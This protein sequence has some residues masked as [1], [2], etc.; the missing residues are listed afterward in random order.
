VDARDVNFSE[1]IAGGGRGF[2]TGKKHS[3]RLRRSR[4]RG[5]VYGGSD[6]NGGSSESEDETLGMRLARLRREAEEVRIEIEKQE[7]EGRREKEG[8]E[9]EDSVEMQQQGQQQEE[10]KKGEDGGEV[11]VDGVREL[12]RMLNALSMKVRPACTSTEDEFLVRLRRP[13]VQSRQDGNQAGTTSSRAEATTLQAVSDFSSRLIALEAALGVSSHST[14]SNTKPILPTITNLSNQLQVLTSAITPPIAN[15]SSAAQP[16]PY[17]DTI[18]TKLRTLIHESERLTQS[19][20]AA[21]DSLTELH[22][23]R[24]AQISSGATLHGHRSRVRGISNAEP[25][26]TST[27]AAE[28][29]GPGDES[30]K[31]E[32]KLFL[33]QQSAKITALYHLLPTIHDLQPLLPTVLERLRTLSVLHN[34]AANAKHLVDELEERQRVMKEEIARWKEGLEMVEQGIKDGGE[35]MRE[36]VEIIGR[37]VGGIEDRVILLDKGR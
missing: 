32:S 19:R 21:L 29:D 33:D 6:E 16:T 34:G 5:G 31:L 36:N 9:F 3:R 25:A 22:E 18:A 37:R 7:Q 4:G 1:S 14:T 24:M 17:L 11:N 2:R 10:G 30:A 15:S 23:K 12:S 13:P 35:V 27:P 8:E 20:K 26:S 28:A